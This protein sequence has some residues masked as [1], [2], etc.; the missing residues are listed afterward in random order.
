MVYVEV[1]I[2]LLVGFIRILMMGSTYGYDNRRV[3]IRGDVKCI[4]EHTMA[5]SKMVKQLRGIPEA[6]DRMGAPQTLQF[7]DLRIPLN[8]GLI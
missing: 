6:G 1:E 4:R 8:A 2:F 3:S 5:C 7:G